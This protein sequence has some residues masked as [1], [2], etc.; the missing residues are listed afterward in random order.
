MARKFDRIN[1][2]WKAFVTLIT[3]IQKF[4]VSKNLFI[5]LG[6]RNYKI[7]LFIKDELKLS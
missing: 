4:G 6:E 1:L 7:L 5:F 2:K 3:T